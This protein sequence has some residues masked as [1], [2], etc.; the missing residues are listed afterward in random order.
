MA[1]ARLGAAARMRARGGWA[2]RWRLAPRRSR[3]V[4][5]ALRTRAQTR[6]ACKLRH[7][8]CALRASALLLRVCGRRE[9]QALAAAGAYRRAERARALS[10]PRATPAARTHARRGAARP[11][12]AAAAQRALGRMQRSMWARNRAVLHV[13]T[14]KRAR[15]SHVQV[16]VNRQLYV[17]S[18][19]ISCL[20][21]SSKLLRA[22]CH[23][24][25]VP[26]LPQ[27]AAACKAHPPRHACRQPYEGS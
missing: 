1:G 13:L 25:G 22:S 2:P 15:P 3:G 9:A 6:A 16:R 19:A 18:A 17:Q 24:N 10:A 4:H 21:N 8:C 11:W 5:Q 23:K 14:H 20:C 26:A 7:G 27:P 12:R